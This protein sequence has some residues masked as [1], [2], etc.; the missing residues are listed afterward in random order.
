[1]ADSELAPLSQLGRRLISDAGL[2]LAARLLAPLATLP[3]LPLVVRT[4]GDAGFGTLTVLLA[5]TAL[6][7]VLVA[8]IV[9][10]LPI[11]MVEAEE[12]GRPEHAHALLR[13]CWCACAGASA[14]ALAV[15]WPLATWLPWTAWLDLDPAASSP[16]ILHLAGGTTFAGLALAPAE[17]VWRARHAL[18]VHARWQIAATAAGLAAGLAILPGRPEPHW[19]AAIL[20]LPPVA[21][22]ACSAAHLL[23]VLPRLPRAPLAE[24]AQDLARRVRLMFVLELAAAIGNQSDAVVLAAVCGPVAAA[25]L[26]LGMR[27]FSVPWLGISALL[28]VLPPAYARAR[29]RDDLAWC[30]STLRWTTALCV[31]ATAAWGA[32]L[33]A[34]GDWLTQAFTDGAVACPLALRVGLG[35]WLTI[36]A[37]SMCL[38]ALLTG[39]DALARPARWALASALCN[40]MLSIPF[41]RWLGSG[42]VICASAIAQGLLLGLPAWRLVRSTLPKVRP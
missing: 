38:G 24:A 37:A 25:Q 20:W 5:A 42:G 40:L 41:A 11:A 26:A 28:A 1:M 34:V 35:A 31:G 16:A 12:A 3:L 15:W 21:G 2:T 13:V 36:G 17:A 39:F 4:V 22:A 9:Q 30:R 32:L 6:L 33:L 23:A 14:V 8:P 7:R 18:R 27:I 29:A 10:S 19:V